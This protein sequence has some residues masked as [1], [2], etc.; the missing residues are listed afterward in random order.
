MFEVPLSDEAVALLRELAQRAGVTPEEFARRAILDRMEDTEDYLLA[1]ER[2]RTS[3]GETVP[4]EEVMKEFS[5]D[6]AD[7]K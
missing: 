1:E 3:T 6:L 2:L 4:L 5:D 7:V